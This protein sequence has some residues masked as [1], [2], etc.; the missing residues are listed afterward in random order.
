MNGHGFFWFTNFINEHVLRFLG[1][2]IPIVYNKLPGYPLLEPASRLARPWSLSTSGG[3]TQR[4]GEG[5]DNRYPRLAETPTY[6]PPLPILVG[7]IILATTSRVLAGLTTTVIV[8]IAAFASILVASH[9]AS[10]HLP[11]PQR[12]ANADE[13]PQRSA[14]LLGSLL[15]AGVA[16]LLPFRP[17]RSTTP[18]PRTSRSLCCSPQRSLMQS[19]PRT[20]NP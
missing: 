13:H 11:A 19:R 10:D 15:G 6:C 7:F 16:L 8:V 20:L 2:R 12:S 14:L 1:R 17:I 3:A 9:R 4:Y 18:S 5:F